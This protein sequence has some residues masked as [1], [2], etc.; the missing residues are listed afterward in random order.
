MGMLQKVFHSSAWRQLNVGSCCYVTVKGD[1]LLDGP[2][3]SS[4]F[5]VMGNQKF[6]IYSRDHMN[7]IIITKICKLKYSE[8]SIHRFRR[9]SEKETMDQGKQ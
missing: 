8:T 6:I 7:I 1:S 9:V 4:A 3:K 5:W 2:T